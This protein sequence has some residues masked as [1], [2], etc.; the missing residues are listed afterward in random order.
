MGCMC[1]ERQKDYALRH[2]LRKLPFRHEARGGYQDVKER[3]KEMV[4]LRQ[5]CGYHQDVKDVHGDKAGC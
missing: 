3:N 5:K 1:K 4:L 2:G